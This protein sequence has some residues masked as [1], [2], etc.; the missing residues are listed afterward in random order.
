MT[1][2]ISRTSSRYTLY[3]EKCPEALDIHFREKCL[4]DKTPLG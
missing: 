4:E 1:I 3:A 2:V